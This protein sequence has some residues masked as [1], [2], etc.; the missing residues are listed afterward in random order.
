MSKF[1]IIL[2][3]ILLISIIVLICKLSTYKGSFDIN[4]TCS[5]EKAAVNASISNLSNTYS[6]YNTCMENAI[7]G[8]APAPDAN[9]PIYLNQINNIV[10]GFQTYLVHSSTVS[11]V[12]SDAMTD[13]LSDNPVMVRIGNLSAV[14]VI[15]SVVTAINNK[16]TGNI[17]DMGNMTVMSIISDAKNMTQSMTEN[18]KTK[19]LDII[20]SVIWDAISQTSADVLI[21][22]LSE[23]I[24]N[25]D[26]SALIRTVVSNMM[27][28]LKG[29]A[30][31]PQYPDIL[32]KYISSL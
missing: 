10:N 30:L 3:S 4:S 6:N 2:M 17:S 19:T 24:T 14:S 5:P 23:D 18:I 8:L 7:S 20:S 22:M 21:G 1:K 13:T 32:Q 26:E 16:F 15:N 11:D 29:A 25:A 27:S 12:L 28:H 9:M 31:S